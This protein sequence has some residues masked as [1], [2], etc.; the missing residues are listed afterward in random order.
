MRLNSCCSRGSVTNSWCIAH[1]HTWDHMALSTN[2]VTIPKKVMLIGNMLVYMM[3][4][5]WI[6]IHIQYAYIYMIYCAYKLT[7]LYVHFI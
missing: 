2:G 4:K 6:L 7:Y 1:I 3:V 5:R